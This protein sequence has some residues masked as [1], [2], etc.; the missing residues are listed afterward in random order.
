MRLSPLVLLLLAPVPLPLVPALLLAKA[1]G[2]LVM[3]PIGGILEPTSV[4]SRQE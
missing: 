1:C 3:A 4:V 2:W